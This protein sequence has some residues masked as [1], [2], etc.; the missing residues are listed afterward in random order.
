[1][2]TMTSILMLVLTATLAGPVPGLAGLR[3]VVRDGP[4]LEGVV[5]LDDVPVDLDGVRD[6]ECTAQDAEDAFGDGGLA[7]AGG[8]VHED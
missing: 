7:V 3:L 1:M 6:A 5:E 4:V 2:K 8:A